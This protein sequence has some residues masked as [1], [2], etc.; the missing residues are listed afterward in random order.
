MEYKEFAKIFK[1]EAPDKV[2]IFHQEIF[3][4]WNKI[5]ENLKS[6]SNIDERGFIISNTDF[7]LFPISTKP[8]T[9]QKKGNQAEAKENYKERIRKELKKHRDSL[10]KHKNKWIMLYLIAYLNKE[11]YENYDV[12]NIPK[13]F[14]DVLKEF[15]SDDERGDRF[16]ETLIVEKRL[17][18]NLKIPTSFCEE[19]LVFIADAK[20]KE[21]FIK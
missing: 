20:Y 17:L 13:H 7:T 16:I 10:S 6:T 5:T 12:D 3:K 18:D 11:K 21:H 8:K 4:D 19:F 15:T 14:C 9:L 2:L 1:N